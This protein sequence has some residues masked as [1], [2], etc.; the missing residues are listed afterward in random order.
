MGFKKYLPFILGVILFSCNS[1]KNTEE[2]K[3]LYNLD[4]AR[5]LGKCYDELTPIENDP[6]YNYPLCSDST[7]RVF[8]L[9][10][11]YYCVYNE[12]SG[13]CGSGGCALSFYKK[14]NNQY[15]QIPALVWQGDID[16][17]QEVKDYVV[18]SYTYKRSC[19]WSSYSANIKVKNDKVYFDE[20]IEYNHNVI[21]DVLN[22]E[23]HSDTCEYQDSS[24]VLE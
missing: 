22:K 7:V 16:I 19:C 18:Y 5:E 4:I 21:N 1:D 9:E 2:V 17:H 13:W 20:I 23:S 3:D 24:W 10:P 8:F 15:I 14:E 11:N 12:S 6:E